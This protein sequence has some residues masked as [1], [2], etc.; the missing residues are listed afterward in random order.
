MFRR[1]FIGYSTI[2]HHEKTRDAIMKESQNI[3]VSGHQ[4][5]HDLNSFLFFVMKDR[6]SSTKQMQMQIKASQTALSTNQ[7]WF[8]EWAGAGKWQTSNVS[9]CF[10]PHPK[11]KRP[12]CKHSSPTIASTG[13]AAMTGGAG[14]KGRQQPSSLRP[15]S[16]SFLPLCYSY[17]VAA[18]RGAI[19]H[20][21]LS[22]VCQD[23]G[24]R[25]GI[26]H[27]KYPHT[28][29]DVQLR[30]AYNKLVGLNNEMH[31]KNK[32]TRYRGDGSPTADANT[33]T[34]SRK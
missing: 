32:R 34:E 24:G 20:S 33:L 1:L 11:A 25:S 4:K 17:P 21:G 30:R 7:R 23:M 8:R 2:F 22:V 27:A 12:A 28:L 14:A 19:I 26:T 6:K 31:I 16:P 15:P 10:P 9:F 18:H 5:F 29:S 3:I 13:T